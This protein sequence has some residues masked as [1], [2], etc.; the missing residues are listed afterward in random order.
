VRGVLR[1]EK[2]SK[3]E[4]KQQF[5]KAGTAVAPLMPHDFF[6]LFTGPHYNAAF[7]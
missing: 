1:P 6:E 2:N 7:N 4:K 5:A 3:A